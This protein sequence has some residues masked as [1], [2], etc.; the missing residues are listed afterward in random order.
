MDNAGE[1]SSSPS[2]DKSRA[3]LGAPLTLEDLDIS[4]P[5]DSAH[6]SQPDNEDADEGGWTHIASPPIPTPGSSGVPEGSAGLSSSQVGHV[7]PDSCYDDHL[8]IVL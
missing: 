8:Y 7:L 2:R 6:V 4:S 5:E 1:L 3:R